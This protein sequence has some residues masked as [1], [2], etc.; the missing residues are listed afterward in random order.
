MSLY[1]GVYVVEGIIVLNPVRFIVNNFSTSSWTA[2]GAEHPFSRLEG[3]TEHFHFYS[4]SSPELRSNSEN[5]V[6]LMYVYGI[7]TI[8]IWLV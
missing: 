2:I 8:Y 3:R 6:A 1:S 4:T 5:I 7:C